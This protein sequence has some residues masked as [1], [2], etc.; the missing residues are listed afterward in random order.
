MC[1]D[2]REKTL[3]VKY[4]EK[5]MIQT[6]PFFAGNIL[7]HEGYRHLGNYREYVN[8]NQILDRVFFVGASPHYDDKTFSYMETILSGYVPTFSKTLT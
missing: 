8:A 6:R 7:V 3:L 5:N 4:L 2:K 1:D